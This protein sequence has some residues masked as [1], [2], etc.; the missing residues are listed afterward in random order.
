MFYGV[1]DAAS[2]SFRCLHA[3]LYDIITMI[4]S[5]YPRSYRLRSSRLILIVLSTFAFYRF[6][7]LGWGFGYSYDASAYRLLAAFMGPQARRVDYGH[8][9]EWKGYTIKPIAYVFPQFHPIPENDKFWGENFTEWVNVKKA[10]ENQYGLETLHP[11]KDI[12][13]YN[14]MDY[15]VRK[16][17]AKLVR[18]SGY[19]FHR[20][21]TTWL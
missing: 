7:N 3:S 19:A 1:R 10:K 5:I 14:L 20:R 11:T 6:L 4:K 9:T 12:G 8:K 2:L 18:D 13:Y 15:D 17:Y 21:M 16:R